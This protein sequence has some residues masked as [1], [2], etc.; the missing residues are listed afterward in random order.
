MISADQLVANLEFIRNLPRRSTENPSV[1]LITTM[2]R[3]EAAHARQRLSRL[4]VDVDGLNARNLALIDT[5]IMVL[6]MSD[7]SEDYLPQ[8][9]ITLCIKTVINSNKE[10]RLVHYRG[11]NCILCLVIFPY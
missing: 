11:L 8:L 2:C 6:V 5:A 9:V 7:G 4:T 3:D 1:C 10:F